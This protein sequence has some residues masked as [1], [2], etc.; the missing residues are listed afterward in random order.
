MRILFF[1]KSRY[2]GTPYN[3]DHRMELYSVGIILLISTVLLGGC[4][5]PNETVISPLISET[6]SIEIV[7]SPTETTSP[8]LQPS[9][10]LTPSP[11][12]TPTLESTATQEP[13]PTRSA[14]EKH[15]DIRYGSPSKGQELDVY[16]PGQIE[17]PYPVILML[18]QGNGRKEQFIS[19]GKLFAKE[20]FAVAASNYRGWPNYTFPQDITDAFCA[21]GWVHANA[22]D[23]GFDTSK[24]YVLGQSAGGTLA[25]LIGSVDDPSGYMRICPDKLPVSGWVQGVVTFTGIFDYA[26]AARSS[27][28][29][30]SYTNAL[31]GGNQDANPDNWAA[32]SALNW[33]DGAEPPFLI[34]HGGGDQTIPSDQSTAFAQALERAGVSVELVIVPEADHQQITGSAETLEITL[35][36]LSR[37][38]KDQ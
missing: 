3:S 1:D 9:D 6:P 13:S 4:D 19:W 5:S 31:L 11:T 21:L 24:V 26:S 10:T 23:Y 18:H 17:G 34:F 7:S 15:E 30:R 38:V 36:F 12:S 27:S 22:A 29:L 32:A 2:E 28:A 33:I 14:V 16:L 37:L 25:A 20:G 8:T 35:E